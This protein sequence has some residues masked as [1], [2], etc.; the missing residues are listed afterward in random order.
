MLCT[1]PGENKNIKIERY[2]YKLIR[3]FISRVDPKD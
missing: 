1:R 2:K 3:P